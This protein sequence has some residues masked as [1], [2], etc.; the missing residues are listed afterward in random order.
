VKRRYL[1]IGL[2]QLLSI[3]LA[4]WL[5]RASWNEI[6][7][8][9][10]PSPRTAHLSLYCLAGWVVTVATAIWFAAVDKANRTITVLFLVLLL[11]SIEFFGWF[12]LSF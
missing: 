1:V 11:P 4:G 3:F 6:D 8:A 12:A 2:A 7:F 9:G 10:A 5:R